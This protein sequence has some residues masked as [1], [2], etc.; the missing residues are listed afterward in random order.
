MNERRNVLKLICDKI[1][2]ITLFVF[3]VQ[4]NKKKKKSW[5]IKR[6]EIEWKV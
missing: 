4:K 6:N 1:V 3:S 2:V 5:N